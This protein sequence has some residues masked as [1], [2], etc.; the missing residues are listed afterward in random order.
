[1]DAFDKLVEKHFPKNPLN[2][3]MEMVEK[4]LDGLEPKKVLK[5]SREVPQVPI[6]EF[7]DYLPKFEL[8]EKIGEFTPESKN[9]AREMFLEYM[10]GLNDIPGLE[11]KIKYINTFASGVPTGGEGYKI[12]EI[13]TNI[14]FLRM[15]SMVIEQFSPSAA[16]FIFEAFLAAILGGK[17]IVGR[18]EGGALP[19]QDFMKYIDPKTGKGGQPVSLKLLGPETDIEGSLPNLIKFMST[20]PSAATEGIEYVVA[21]KQSDK[22]VEFH[23]FNLNGDSF[24]YWMSTERQAK[25]GRYFDTAKLEQYLYEYGDVLGSLQ[26]AQ[27]ERRDFTVLKQFLVDAFGSIGITKPE[28]SIDMPDGEFIKN[29]GLIQSSYIKRLGLKGFAPRRIY[30]REE[31]LQNAD[32][33]RDQIW[34]RLSKGPDDAGNVALSNEE[35]LNVDDDTA[36]VAILKR[37]YDRLNVY[38]N[39]AVSR[40]SETGL[41]FI[42]YVESA[43][44]GAKET[45]EERGARMRG[46]G[47]EEEEQLRNDLG[48]LW[49]ADRETWGNVLLSSLKPGIDQ[50][51]ISP[52]K[53]KQTADHYGSLVIDKEKIVAIMNQYSEQLREQ[54]IPIYTELA[55]LTNELNKFYLADAV[56]AGGKAANHAK[57]LEDNVVSAVEETQ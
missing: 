38:V 19:I 14:T 13:M 42:D 8:T 26:E 36:A 49:A 3:L 53:M 21:T 34:P 47:K 12:S 18:T 48:Q 16:G 52:T 11:D 17:Q 32:L 56:E 15:L 54:V 41:N 33:W 7:Y 31:A 37:R 45:E 40:G 22:V 4:E 20:D 2:V 27:E 46:L 29:T 5:E 51:I 23:S 50:F 25:L 1:M 30:N 28:L 6:D 57:Q 24:V 39:Q 55:K 43:I 10:T 9:E 35:L 44:E